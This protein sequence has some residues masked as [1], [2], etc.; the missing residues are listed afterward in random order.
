M[1]YQMPDTITLTVECG[2]LKATITEE[3]HTI[4]EFLDQCRRAALALGY[5]PQT[6]DEAILDAA[7]DLRQDNEPST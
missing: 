3:L 2:T 6:W 7:D 5:Q 4:T 1:I